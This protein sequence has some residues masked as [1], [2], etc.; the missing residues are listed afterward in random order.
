MYWQQSNSVLSIANEVDDSAGNVGEEAYEPIGGGMLE[1]EVNQGVQQNT[2][3]NEMDSLTKDMPNRCP[4]Q[5]SLNVSFRRF[6]N[7]S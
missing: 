4:P 1:T 3:E 7:C 5:L 6:P 2:L